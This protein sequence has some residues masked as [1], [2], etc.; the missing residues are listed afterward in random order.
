MIRLFFITIL[1]F[2]GY[3]CAGAQTI[4]KAGL[5]T[6]HIRIGEQVQLI[7]KCATEAQRDVTFPSYESEEEITPGVEVVAQSGVD[8]LKLNGGKRVE[9]TRRYTIT[10]FD[11]AL[12]TL[13]PVTVEVDGKPYRSGRQIG[14]KVNT[15][16]VDTTNTANF[17]PAHA[18]VM[19]AFE[20]RGWL[21]WLALA[22]WGLLLIVVG[23]LVRL[24]DTRPV[25]RRVVI[26][27]PTPAHVPA[28]SSID[29]LKTADKSDA[30]GYY[31]ALTDTL[32]TYIQERFGINA[33][34]M[35][36]TEILDELTAEGNLDALHELKS[37]LQTAD[38]VKFAKMRPELTEQD[39]NLVDAL[40]FV[41]ATKL[42]P[43]EKP[44]P[45]VEFVTLSEKHQ[46]R[47]RRMM[48]AGLFVATIGC[49]ALLIYE[50]VEIYQ[51]FL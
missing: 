50:L 16:P 38:L 3:S 46:H 25:M 24:S 28:F 12:Y 9:L 20:W 37:V 47:V 30:K 13:P 11:S 39:R 45:R 14:L 32:R 10:S 2:I 36:S 29:R 26:P 34:E 5:D 43:I 8:T 40:D 23:L 51:T 31:M 21:L 18:P 49:L 7:V 48:Q 17:A 33:R 44:K 22:A 35:T 41:T 1:G 42:E 15:V 4:V 19:P 6:A 27:P